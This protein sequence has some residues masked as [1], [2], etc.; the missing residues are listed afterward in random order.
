MKPNGSVRAAHLQLK[1]PQLGLSSTTNLMTSARLR[2]MTV[3]TTD[4]FARV[5][6]G[7][8]LLDLVLQSRIEQHFCGSAQHVS[9]NQSMQKFWLV[10]NRFAK[11]T[12]LHTARGC[13]ASTGKGER[14]SSSILFGLLFG[15]QISDASVVLMSLL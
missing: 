11:A 2:I 5:S 1:E 6:F 10:M 9:S 4:V 12:Y 7:L 3:D 14:E 13:V 8:C 15:F